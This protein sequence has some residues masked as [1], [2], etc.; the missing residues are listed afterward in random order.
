M[1]TY[2]VDKLKAVTDQETGKVSTKPAD[3][4]VPCG[5]NTIIYLAKSPCKW[6]QIN[7]A[8]KTSKEVY[9]FSTWKG[10]NDASLVGDYVPTKIIH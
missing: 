9:V 8:A 2:R 3:Y 6:Q 5:M 7:M 1:T 4:H 10:E